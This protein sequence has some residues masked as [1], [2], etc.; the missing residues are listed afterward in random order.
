MNQCPKCRKRPFEEESLHRK[1]REMFNDVPCTCNFCKTEFRLEDSEKHSASC[2]ALNYKCPAK[3][4]GH[5]SNLKSVAE[6]T[7]HLQTKCSFANIICIKCDTVLLRGH[8]SQHDCVKSLKDVI[9][10]LETTI[11]E[12]RSKEDKEFWRQSVSARLTQTSTDQQSISK[13]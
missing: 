8:K 5:L 13:W 10:Q 12:L 3:G 7:D 4:C 9:K 11:F 6:L 2:K 1:L